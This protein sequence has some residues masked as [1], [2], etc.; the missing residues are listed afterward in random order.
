MALFI[1]WVC[2][3]GATNGT[4]FAMLPY[5]NPT[6]VGGVAGIVG[7]GGNF[8]ALIGNV[9]IGF[10]F[11]TPAQVKPSRNLAFLALGWYGISC[12]LMIPL[13]WLPG[14]G[15]MFR[16]SDPPQPPPESSTTFSQRLDPLSEETAK[17]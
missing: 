1:I 9:M 16:R 10:I 13:L 4:H 12:T 6:C 8:G 11:S 17:V 3:E 15:S 5:I 14:Q 7:A 2:F